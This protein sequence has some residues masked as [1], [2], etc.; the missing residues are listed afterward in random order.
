[1]PLMY[2]TLKGWL[3]GYWAWA[4]SLPWLNVHR[5]NLMKL[6]QESLHKKIAKNQFNF[7]DFISQIQQIKKMGN[8]KELASMIPG[9]GKA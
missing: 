3:T 1:M 9:V 7:D 2:F 4:I 5:S 6:N 8:L